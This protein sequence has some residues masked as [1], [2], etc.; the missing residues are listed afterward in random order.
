MLAGVLLGNYGY[1]QSNS[2]TTP[3]GYGLYSALRYLHH[4]L[5]YKFIAYYYL[6]Q[7]GLIIEFLFHR[8]HRVICQIVLVSK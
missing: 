2:E 3:L 5:L 6:C 7:I 1:L 4:F 8:V